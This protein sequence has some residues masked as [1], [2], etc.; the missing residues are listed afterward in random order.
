MKNILLLTDFSQNS[1]NAIHYALNL[2]NED[3]CSF[4]ILHVKSSASYTTD[5]LMT[6]GNESIYNSIV[7]SEKKKI[8]SLIAELKRDY[9]TENFQF[10]AIVD[11]DVLTD[12]INQVVKAKEI[13]LIVMGSNGVTGAKEVIFGSNT[14]NVIRKVNCDTLVIPEDFEYIKPKEVLLPLDSSD[15]ISGSAFLRLLKFVKKPQSFIHILRINPSGVIPDIQS[16]DLNHTVYFLKDNPYKYNVV[17]NIPI[18]EVVSTY[19]QTNDINLTALI[20]QKESL[21][22]RFFMGSPTT[23]IGNHL[24]VPLL[25]FH[26]D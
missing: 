20:V 10:D 1:S 7:A 22:E 4:V 6:A 9:K 17:N 3:T 25:V 14:V 23:K 11:Y 21:F 24:Q 26:E 19:I 13:D 8:A 2:F 12:A 18:D 15:S 5:D 16:E